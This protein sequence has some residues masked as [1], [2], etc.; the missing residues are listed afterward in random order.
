M[1]FGTDA[2][3]PCND[4][5]SHLYVNS[6]VNSTE[7][8]DVVPVTLKNQLKINHLDGWQVRLPRPKPSKYSLLHPKMHRSLTQNFTHQKPIYYHKQKGNEIYDGE[9]RM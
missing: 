4:P 5:A 3:F 9:I 6:F 1:I 8:K 2:F 7:P